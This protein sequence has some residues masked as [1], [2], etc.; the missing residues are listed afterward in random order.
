MGGPG[1]G[2]KGHSLGQ[3]AMHSMIRNAANRK[4]KQKPKY[5]LSNPT[6]KAK[7]N[8]AMREVFGKK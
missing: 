1:S 3:V 6:H 2:R 4:S 8:K 5:D 7:F